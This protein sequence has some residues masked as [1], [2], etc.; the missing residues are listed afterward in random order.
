MSTDTLLPCHEAG[1]T[2]LTTGAARSTLHP[3][4]DR[5]LPWGCQFWPAGDPVAR[6][7]AV[8]RTSGTPGVTS[9]GPVDSGCRAGGG[10]DTVPAPRGALR[11]GIAWTEGCETLHLSP[12][13]SGCTSNSVAAHDLLTAEDEVRLSAPWSR[14]ARPNRP[15]RPEPAHAPERAQSCTGRSTAPTSQGRVH[16]QQPSPGDLDRQALHRHGASTSSTWSRR[17]TS[18]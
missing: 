12:M 18:G 10:G 7:S 14:A 13:A 16:P 4:L 3:P 17:A 5:G 1:Q 11:K 9:T 6:C 2:L 8:G 15:R